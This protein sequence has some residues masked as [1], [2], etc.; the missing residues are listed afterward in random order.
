MLVFYIVALSKIQHKYWIEGLASGGMS[1]WTKTFE[2]KT[3]EFH[4][5]QGW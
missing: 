3:G 2:K 5:F 4:Y 1:Q